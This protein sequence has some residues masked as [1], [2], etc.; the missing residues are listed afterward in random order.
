[1]FRKL[2]TQMTLFG[3]CMTGFLLILFSA[4]C[5]RLILD[6]L[7][8]TGY[9]S[10]LSEMNGDILHLQEKD[11]I[12]LSWIGQLQE[13]S[14]LQLF[15]Y[16]NQTPLYAQTYISRSLEKEV[17]SEEQEQLAE[18]VIEYAA[19]Q[20][21]LDIRLPINSHIT[22]HNEF[23]FLSA[24]GERYYA[25]VGRVPKKNGQ[26]GFVILYP[27]AEQQRKSIQIILGICIL[28][29]I[30]LALLIL[31]FWYFTAAMIRPLKEAQEKQA[32]FIASASHELRAPLAV[33]QS[34]LEVLSKTEDFEERAHFTRLLHEEGMRMKHL[35][36]EL[37]MLARSDS[38]E[39]ELN[40]E[41]CQPDSL[42]LD[43]YEKSEPVAAK[44]NIYLSVDLPEELMED[45]W[46]DTQRITQAL[47]ILISNAISY[48]PREG[49]V[50]LSLKQGK[51]R[52]DFVVSDTGCGIPD[53]EKTRIF[54]R[55]YRCDQSRTDKEH[56]GLGLCI[57]K[58]I[59]D[60][61]GGEI[62]VEDAP[63]GGSCF[64]LRL[65]AK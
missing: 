3:V 57:A 37:L 32:L 13:N 23:S 34:G 39:M 42:L 38:Q 48:T 58:E 51:Q 29:I 41:K 24:A 28:D 35:V 49:K 12:S 2:Q 10:F 18:E 4:L 50:R 26:L 16:D 59:A 14:N 1:M 5:L 30:S 40:K 62:W 47:E 19:A 64:T 65:P 36:D 21:A 46:L 25:S 61:H 54:E 6:N 52:L 8:S 44:K 20:Y 11:D 45:V 53:Q 55:F 33:W 31:F 27:L 22:E 56:F 43:I 7:A 17:S 60:A 63:G 15:L 9:Q